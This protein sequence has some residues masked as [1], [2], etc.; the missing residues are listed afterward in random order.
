MMASD[1]HQWTISLT[2]FV[3]DESRRLID[4]LPAEQREAVGSLQQWSAKD[5][6]AHLVYWIEVLGSNIEAQIDGQPLTDTSDSLHMNDEAWHIRKDWTWE[7]VDNAL[8]Q[9]LSHVKEQL[10]RLN[11]ADL[12]DPQ[13]FTIEYQNDHPYP[14]L[15]SLVYDLIDHP[16]LH[17]TELYCKTEQAEKA[18][19]LVERTLVLLEQ[20]GD[21]HLLTTTRYNAACTYAAV[22][23]PSRALVL[24]HEAQTNDSSIGTTAKAD[25]RLQSLWELSDFKVLVSRKP[26]SFIGNSYIK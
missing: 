24:L 13:R 17:F 21:P 11:S 14:L 5:E 7:K 3:H 15:H 10:T 20:R 12:I 9:A 22:G 16:V 23:N 4:N 6:L 26:T 18:T 19:A 2:D 8:E 1:I 25:T